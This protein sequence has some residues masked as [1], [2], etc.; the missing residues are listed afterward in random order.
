[1]GDVLR[2]VMLRLRFCHRLKKRRNTRK[3]Q[4]LNGS[5]LWNVWMSQKMLMF[6][7]TGLFEDV[8]MIFQNGDSYFAS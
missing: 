1:M 4:N 8:F 6:P 5:H 2:S 3:R 7:N